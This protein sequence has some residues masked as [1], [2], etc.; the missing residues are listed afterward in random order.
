M[1][2]D[3]IEGRDKETEEIQRGFEWKKGEGNYQKRE[4]RAGRHFMPLGQA[5]VTPL[6]EYN[7]R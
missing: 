7:S 4:G 3:K 6:E 5:A 2:A 1:Q